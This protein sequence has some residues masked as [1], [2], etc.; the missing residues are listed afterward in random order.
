MI[1]KVLSILILVVL[2]LTGACSSEPTTVTVPPTTFVV[3]VPAQTVTPSS[4]Q[5]AQFILKLL[6]VSDKLA[7]S[8]SSRTVAGEVQNISG[9][10]QKGIQ[11]M[12]T[13]YDKSEKVVSTK[14]G[15]LGVDLLESEQ[16]STFEVTSDVV[17]AMD[18]YKI[19]FAF[20]SGAKIPYT[21]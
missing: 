15:A 4:T 6:S 1:K 17:P 2:L 21:K 8:G 13:W 14:A 19:E 10:Q 12:V 3:T 9:Q 7:A 18:H 16:K 20:V 5:P 11:V